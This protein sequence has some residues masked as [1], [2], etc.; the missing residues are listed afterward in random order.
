MITNNIWID[1]ANAPWYAHLIGVILVAIGAYLVWYH[2]SPDRDKDD[3]Y[4]EFM[5]G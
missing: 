1:F 4:E 3:D 5:N 2:T